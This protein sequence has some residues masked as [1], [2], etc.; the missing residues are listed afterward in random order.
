MKFCNEYSN[1]R[2]KNCVVNL[3][4]GGAVRV[5]AELLKV[6]HISTPDQPGVSAHIFCD[7]VL[8]VNNE[9]AGM[10]LCLSPIHYNIVCEG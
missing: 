4:D 9:P 7:N 8:I 10:A 3:I 2:K 6:I 5:D 1:V